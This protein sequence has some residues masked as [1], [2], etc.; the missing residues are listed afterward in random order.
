MINLFKE[1]ASKQ[2]GFSFNTMLLTGGCS[3][4][5]DLDK[6]HKFGSQII[7][8]TPGKLEQ[9]LKEVPKSVKEVEVVVMDEA[10][11]LLD[12]GFEQSVKGILKML[13]RQRRTGLFSATMTD[14]LSELTKAGLRNPVK[15]VVTVEDINSG[16]TQRIP[17]SLDVEYMIMNSA[18]KYATLLSILKDHSESKIIVFFSTCACVDYFHKISSKM[19]EALDNN[20]PLLA[21]HGKMVEKKR[22]ALFEKFNS[23]KNAVL[24]TTDVAARGI[25]IPDVDLVIQYDPPQDP[26][27]FLHRCGRT[28]RQG[29]SGKALLFLR[30]QEDTFIEFIELKGVPMKGN[31]YTASISAIE[32]LLVIPDL[33]DLYIPNEKDSKLQ[34]FVHSC[35][36]EDREVYT[37]SIIAFTSFMRAYQEHQL[38][39]IFAFKKLDMNDL[40][41]SFYLLH[42][43]KCP[44]SKR[45]K[46]AEPFINRIDLKSISKIAFLDRNKEKH[47]LEKMAKDAG[48]EKKDT[49]KKK[50]TVAWSD[51]KEIK[52][53]R[54]ERKEKRAAK[55]EA[56]K[57]KSEDFNEVSENDEDDWKEIQEETRIMK[58]VKQGKLS[59]EDADKLL[60]T[61]NDIVN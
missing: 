45:L 43:P 41:N 48:V 33:P 9:F 19:F 3:V 31:N 40:L 2:A 42:A 26:Q 24:F 54:Q 59:A 32:D 36:L 47:R 14:A 55:R 20:R 56:I 5:E 23:S 25:D 52:E 15:V 28:A 18:E 34:R 11:R 51:K 27:A 1:A 58:K 21:L 37:K 13:P 39:Y 60:F 8:A 61:E 16:N 30:E 10:D 6:F 22:K 50:I 17:S 29:R 35:I 4:T 44:E 7:V 57:R 53:K 38:S 49:H 12:L 46:S